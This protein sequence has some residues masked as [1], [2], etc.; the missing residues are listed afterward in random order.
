MCLNSVS[1]WVSKSNFSL[2]V[3]VGLRSTLGDEFRF[4]N[5]LS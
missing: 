4:P 5:Q 2:R 1:S 3:E